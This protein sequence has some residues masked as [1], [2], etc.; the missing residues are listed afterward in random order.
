MP[1]IWGRIIMTAQI[2]YADDR[3][4]GCGSP[5]EFEDLESAVRIYCRSFD[6]IFSKALGSRVYD[7]KGYRY[8]DFLAGAGALSYGHN[9]PMIKKAVVDYL[10][11]D[12]ILSSLDLHTTAKLAFLRKFNDVILAPRKLD[13]RVQFCGPTGANAIEAALK[14]ARKVTAR[15]TVVAFTNAFHGASLGAL[16][17]TANAK[18]RAAAGMPLD[19]VVR[20]PF[21][22]FPGTGNDSLTY[23]EAMLAPGSGIETPASIVVETIQAEGGIQVASDD[24]LRRL[25]DLARHRGILLI[26]DDIQ[27]GCGRSGTFFSFEHAGIVPDMV[28]LSKAIGGIGMPMSLNLIRPDLD[29]WKPGEHNGTFRGNNLGFVA[30]AAALDYWR[31]P[32]FEEAIRRRGNLMRASL[33]GVAG[34][35]PDGYVAVRGRGM[36]QGLVCADPGW[37]SEIQRRAF[38]R[39]LIVETCGA[40][41]EVVKLLPPL[42]IPDD[43]L[44][45]GLSILSKAADE[46]AIENIRS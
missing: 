4:N 2:E 41:D 3:W 1:S 9:D 42:N 27:V 38:E 31:E 15:T 28:C 35:H 34:R 36:I 39:G 44:Q 33:A 25:A 17:V 29:L 40:R 45:E 30:A 43:L 12:G 5:Q 8:I 10:E 11:A 20:M 18:M 26:V 13:Y 24:W 21:D 22:G 32:D 16:A 46:I 14:L 23:L 6:V 19:G 7:Q 37:T